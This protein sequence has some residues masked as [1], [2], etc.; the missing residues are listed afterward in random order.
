MV[1]HSSLYSGYG[2]NMHERKFIRDFIFLLSCFFIYSDA[3][4]WPFSNRATS[5]ETK[6]R[7]RLPTPPA[8]Y[9]QLSNSDGLLVGYGQ[10]DSREEAL[11]LARRDIAGQIQSH[12]TTE[13]HIETRKTDAAI[14]QSFSASTI[15]R[16]DVILGETE[17]FKDELVN[18]TWYVAVAMDNSPL[19]QRLSRKAGFSLCRTDDV[20]INPYV[21]DTALFKEVSSE[22]KCEPSFRLTRNDG[23]WHVTVGK[24]IVALKKSDDFPY[25]WFT[26]HQSDALRLEI[27]PRQISHGGKFKL[28]ITSAKN[29]Y[30]TIFNAY[31][32][33][34]VSELA[35]NIPVDSSRPLLFPE[36]HFSGQELV[37]VLENTHKAAQEMY[38]V[39]FDEN[40]RGND[41]FYLATSSIQ[42]G[43]NGAMMDRLIESLGGVVFSSAILR[44][45][46]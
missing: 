32:A 25:Y 42:Y 17:L 4:A 7:P 24:A 30:V 43:E 36:A 6:E 21:R 12:I 38:V 16:S 18:S 34:M 15:A 8:W 40:L 9:G 35:A 46:P 2:K 41:G 22:L 29:G 3:L 19:S 28:R 26:S 27:E 45:V 1:M 13:D 5:Q 44:I 37:G 20:R 11:G 10:A 14:E 23:R 31:G 39:V 33:G